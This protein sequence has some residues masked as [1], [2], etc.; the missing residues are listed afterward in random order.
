VTES[1]FFG[2]VRHADARSEI[3]WVQ[4][5]HTCRLVLHRPFIPLARARP[6]P[7]SHDICIDAVAQ[8]HN[9]V[10]I[11]EARFGLRRLSHAIIFILFQACIFHIAQSSS[12]QAVVAAQAQNRLQAGLGWLG[13]IAKS[14]PMTQ[15]Y[16]N[17]LLSL[18]KLCERPLKDGE[19][20][21]EVLASRQ[22]SRR[23][24]PVPSQ[25]SRLGGWR[26]RI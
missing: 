10:A 22:P 26:I 3:W 25:S 15:D 11:Y 13:Q 24:S 7:S 5:Y 19:V 4:W 14:Y 1:T 9:L 8:I 18:R 23:S 6:V 21:A 2:Q 12:D 20:L 16:L 17:V